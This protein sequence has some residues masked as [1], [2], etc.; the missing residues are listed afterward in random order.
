MLE[1]ESY[2]YFMIISFWLMYFTARNRGFDTNRF[3]G[4]KEVDK[5]IKGSLST[6]RKSKVNL[7]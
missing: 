6:I 4:G 3:R 1:V 2:F 7:S 5:Y